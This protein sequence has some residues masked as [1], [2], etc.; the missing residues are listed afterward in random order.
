MIGKPRERMHLRATIAAAVASLAAASCSAPQPAPTPAPPVARP[1]PPRPAPLPAPVVKDWVDAPQSP[2][3]WTYRRSGDRSTLSFGAA[4]GPSQF[5]LVCLDARSMGLVRHGATGAQPMTIRT[6][7]ATRT[8]ATVF[9]AAGADPTAN[10]TLAP[11][12]SLL[13]AMAFSKG[14]FAVE[15]PGTP[16]LYLP[17]WAEVTRVIEDCRR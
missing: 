10:A 4:G 2:G 6:E 13:D 9:E 14:R 8:L 7:T 3:T 5:D 1:A 17:S 16:A 12:D 11:R 15:V